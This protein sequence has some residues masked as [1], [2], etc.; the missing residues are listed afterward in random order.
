MYADPFAL[1]ERKC[2]SRARV[3][4]TLERFSLELGLPGAPQT[5]ALAALA[6]IR[7]GHDS[8]KVAA[9]LEW[10]EFE[11][12]C[13]KLFSS[14]GYRVKRNVVLTKPRK[15]IDLLATSSLLSLSV[16]CKHYS[17]HVGYGTLARFA[18]EQVERTKLYKRK[19]DHAGPILPLILTLI[20]A[21]TTVV[22]GVPVVPIL[23]LKSFL[24][25]VSP[26]DGLAVVK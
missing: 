8:Q 11:D 10:N 2:G 17:T 4:E 25:S 9:L 5:N 13:A 21:G 1:L 23:K 16:D 18:E 15:Q 19:R 26:Y 22:D 20:E 14:A 7:L 12:L 3:T 24:E 6:L